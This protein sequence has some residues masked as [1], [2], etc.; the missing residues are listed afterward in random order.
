METIIEHY[1]RVIIDKAK[2]NVNS[3]KLKK[4]KFYPNK[5]FE[6]VVTY[7]FL[8]EFLDGSTEDIDIKS[9]VSP[10][11]YYDFKLWE[12]IKNIFKEKNN[13]KRT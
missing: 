10:D 7:T 11:F 8:L 13:D 12:N 5:N 1:K 6:P 9:I 3:I 4:V 2:E